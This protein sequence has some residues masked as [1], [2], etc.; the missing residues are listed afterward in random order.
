M[1]AIIAIMVAACMVPFMVGQ[2][3]GAR[4]SL[5]VNGD[6]DYNATTPDGLPR[7]N[8]NDTV[9]PGDAF[10]YSFELQV[11]KRMHRRP[12]GICHVTR[13]G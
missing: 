5:S 9:Y 1:K 12:R 7:S 2:A 4:C 3:D 8:P 10:L 11:L 6:I 13:C